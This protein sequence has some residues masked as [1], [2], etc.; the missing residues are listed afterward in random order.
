MNEKQNIL[1]VILDAAEQKPRPVRIKFIQPAAEI[2]P[3]GEA[4]AVDWQLDATGAAL[5]NK[6]PGWRHN[7]AGGQTQG[8]VRPTPSLVPSRNNGNK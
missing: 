6:L 7:P 8:R 4:F 5:E 3:N 2:K 1:V